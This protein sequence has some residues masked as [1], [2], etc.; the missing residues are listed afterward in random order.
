MK[1]IPYLAL[2]TETDSLDPHSCKLKIVTASYVEDDSVVDLFFR[3]PEQL[4][5]VQALVDRADS[6][7]YWNAKYDIPVLSRHGV[8]IDLPYHDALLYWRTLRTDLPSYSL[9]Y[10]SRKVLYDMYQEEYD[11]KDWLK[12][13]KTDKF[14]DAPDEILRPYAVKDSRN[15]ITLFHLAQNLLDEDSNREAK[16]GTLDLEHEVQK[17]VLQ[18]EKDGIWLDLPRCYDLYDLSRDKAA[19]SLARC[20]EL[21]NPKFKPLSPKQIREFIYDEENRP[22]RFTPKGSPSTDIMAMKAV[23]DLRA[24]SDVAKLCSEVLVYRA[25]SKAANTYF[26]NFIEMS[27][28]WGVLRCSLN[29][30]GTKTGR[31]SCS[32]PNLQ[33]VPKPD[34]YGDEEKVLLMAREAFIPRPGYCLCFIDYDQVELRMG[35]HFADEAHMIADIWDGKDLHDETAK[36][37]FGVTKDSPD[38]SL[39]RR[40]SKTLNFAVFYGIGPVKFADQLLKMTGKVVSEEEARAMIKAYKEIYPGI[41][42]LFTDVDIQVQ[43]FGYVQNFYGRV[44]AVEKRKAYKGVNYTIQSSS[45]DLMKLKMVEC[46]EFLRDKKSRLLLTVHDELIFELHKTELDLGPQLRSIMEDRESFKVPITCSLE[47]GMRWSSK[48]E[49][50][51]KEVA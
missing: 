11:L 14:T 35:A 6:L 25:Y 23:I 16:Q 27:D 10:I 19:A 17:V 40:Q 24:G 46:N 30:A 1:K 36:R 34:E 7:V 20:R 5:E 42:Q 15:T 33:N 31:F 13:N 37:L 51:P 28:S 47:Y 12:K 22:T 38:W 43:R 8:K 21:T 2:D 3:Y 41:A 45:A 4:P 26:K 50:L 48:A 44:M 49:E 9:K 29:Q 18:M 39:R 32:R